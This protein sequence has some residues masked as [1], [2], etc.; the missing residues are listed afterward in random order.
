[1]VHLVRSNLAEAM[2]RMSD[3]RA[4]HVIR[5]ISK[6][7]YGK[8]E[9]K[10]CMLTWY[11]GAD[12]DQ[13][14]RVIKPLDLPT[15][16]HGEYMIAQHKHRMKTDKKFARN[17]NLLVADYERFVERDNAGIAAKGEFTQLFRK[18][19]KKMS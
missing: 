11:F 7:G 9:I 16:G 10:R 6:L 1:M 2:Y 17:M 13:I 19:A 3:D 14:D 18:Y 5:H 4:E 15:T 8:H 12:A